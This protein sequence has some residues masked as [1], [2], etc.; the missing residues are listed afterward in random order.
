[1]SWSSIDSDRVSAT[2]W[3]V[4]RQPFTF[5]N[6][7]SIPAG[8]FLSA[9]TSAYHTDEQRYK[10]P[11]VFNPWR[12]VDSA[13]PSSFVTTNVEYIAFG[14]GRHAWWVGSCS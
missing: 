12:F 9:A 3:R 8:T 5:S 2:I 6:G 4:A 10:D 7:V 13:R 14:H 1:M 11:T